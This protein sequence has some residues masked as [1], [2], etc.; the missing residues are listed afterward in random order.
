MLGLARVA[1]K[2][3]S[4]IIEPLSARMRR[5]LPN[6]DDLEVPALLLLQILLG[7]KL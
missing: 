1:L 3:P 2:I 5:H 7:G 4:A 6:D